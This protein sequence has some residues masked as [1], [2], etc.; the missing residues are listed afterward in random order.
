MDVGGRRYN[1][2]IHRAGLAFACTDEGGYLLLAG[3]DVVEQ[4]AVGRAGVAARAALDTVDDVALL[5]SIPVGILDVAHEEGGVQPHGA[6][7]DA[8]SAAD[9]VAHGAAS[10]LLT[11][12]DEDARRALGH[13]DVRREKCLTHHWAT[14][15]DL[16]RV[17]GQAT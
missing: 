3:A 7:G 1:E 16:T 9:T 15:D 17:L 5:G 2:A 11:G 10:R 4:G 8:L 14:T 12:E 13:G 6:D